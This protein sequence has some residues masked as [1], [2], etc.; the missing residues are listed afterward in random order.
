MASLELGLKSGM[1]AGHT[2][3]FSSFFRAVKSTAMQPSG[4]IESWISAATSTPVASF[5]FARSSGDSAAK[6]ERAAAKE[7]MRGRKRLIFTSVD[8]SEPVAG[9]QARTFHTVK[10]AT[11]CSREWRWRIR[12]GL[13]LNRAGSIRGFLPSSP[14]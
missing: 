13:A 5:R 4:E 6:A 8:L 3:G 10:L 2:A 11:D 12:P 1:M 14:E 9:A 7:T